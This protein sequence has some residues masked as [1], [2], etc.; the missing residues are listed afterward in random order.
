MLITLLQTAA[1]IASLTLQSTAIIVLLVGFGLLIYQ[2]W[3]GQRESMM[4]ALM[5]TVTNHWTLIEERRMKIR[6]G[7]LKGSY[8]G[9]RPALEKLLA[10]RYHEELESL[11]DDFLYDNQ[12]SLATTGKSAVMEAIVRDF[13]IQDQVFNL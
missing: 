12:S 3:R 11:A 8:R 5:S 2:I 4:S 1:L 7:E 13:S 6:S 9:L 10:E